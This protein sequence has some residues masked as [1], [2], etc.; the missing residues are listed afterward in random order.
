MDNKLIEIEVNWKKYELL[1]FIAEKYK[2][3]FWTNTFKSLWYKWGIMGQVI[4]EFN[5]KREKFKIL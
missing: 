1:K 3:K 4:E 2:S 5:N